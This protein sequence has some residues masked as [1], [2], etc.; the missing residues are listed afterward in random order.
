MA[1]TVSNLP[2]TSNYWDGGASNVSSFNHTFSVS[3]T[4]YYLFTFNIRLH[5]SSST[6]NYYHITVTG[7][8]DPA[9]GAAVP[10][11]YRFTT[12]TFV[13]KMTSTSVTLNFSTANSTNWTVRGNCTYLGPA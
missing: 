13:Y 2:N 5:G 3:K 8:G 1:N 6:N 4:G 7:Q 12:S 11:D 9:G 10:A